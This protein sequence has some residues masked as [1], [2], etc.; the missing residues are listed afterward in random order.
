MIIETRTLWVLASC[1]TTAI[2]F[3][4][5]HLGMS[6]LAAR[7]QRFRLRAPIRYAIGSAVILASYALLD[8]MIDAN[9]LHLAVLFVSAGLPVLIGWQ[10]NPQAP[11]ESWDGV[12]P[13]RVTNEV[14]ALLENS[15]AWRSLERDSLIDAMNAL[16][17]ADLYLRMLRHLQS[18]DRLD[19]LSVQALRSILAQ[20]LGQEDA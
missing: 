18:D 1:F 12:G 14:I 15:A 13:K 9:W 10:I 19:G 7:Y 8:V 11:T 4:L 20:R 17:N 5:L 6:Q 16:D 3:A 2:L